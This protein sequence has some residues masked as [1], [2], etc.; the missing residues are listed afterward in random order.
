LSECNNAK[1]SQKYWDY[2]GEAT[3]ESQTPG[4]IA[5]A[6][7]GFQKE[8]VAGFSLV[9]LAKGELHKKSMIASFPFSADHSQGRDKFR[10]F[11]IQ[12]G[13]F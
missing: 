11:A 13:G 2:R 5:P 9:C 6:A 8:V 7:E 12:T 10:L 1:S 4:L 3:G